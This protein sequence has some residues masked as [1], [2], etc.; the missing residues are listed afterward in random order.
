MDHEELSLL[1][2]ELKKEIKS[3]LKKE[4]A[5]KKE[6]KKIALRLQGQ[7]NN[8]VGE[9]NLF[10]TESEPRKALFTFLR[11]QNKF[12]VNTFNIIDRKAAIMIRINSMIV[13][14]V[15]IFF[16]Y[17]Q[18][19]QHGV[20]IGITLITCSFISLMLAIN[21]SRPSVFSFIKKYTKHVS[22][23]YSQ[24][25]ERIFAIGFND[26]V[27]LEEYEKAFDKIAK[28]QRLQIGNQV[29]AMY[30]FE[31]QQRKAIMLMEF[32]YIGF[33]SGFTIAVVMFVVGVLRTY[34]I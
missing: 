1:K 3:E 27:S 14:V 34:G 11:N 10:Q 15:V 2:K 24:I 25:E 17:I 6:K 26:N 18:Q 16:Q 31:K 4:K 29:R 28:S 12:Y 5:E 7:Q 8:L 32:S 23:K 30:L 9:K 33:L 22:K 20:P 13:S 19:I 21:A